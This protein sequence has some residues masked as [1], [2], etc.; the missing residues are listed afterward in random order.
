MLSGE[1]APILGVRLV[2]NRRCTGCGMTGY[3][4]D[5]NLLCCSCFGAFL[6]RARRRHERRKERKAASSR[7]TPKAEA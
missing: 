7:R 6:E 1:V 5:K 4:G 2:P 3:V